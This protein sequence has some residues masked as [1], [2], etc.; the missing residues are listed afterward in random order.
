[1]ELFARIPKVGE[2][3]DLQDYSIEIK[4]ADLRKVNKILLILML[5]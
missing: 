4:D 5:H 1:L 2:K 3:M